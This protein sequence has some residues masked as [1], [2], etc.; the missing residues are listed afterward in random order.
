MGLREESVPVL[1]KEELPG[2]VSFGSGCETCF[3]LWVGFFFLML[4]MNSHMN[5]Q[6]G[7]TT[8]TVWL[9]RPISD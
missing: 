2:N 3:L 8:E 6:P 5:V 1:H 4:V 7:G 9:S